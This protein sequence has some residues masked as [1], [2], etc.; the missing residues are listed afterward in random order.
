MKSSKNILIAGILF[1]SLIACSSNDTHKSNKN[2]VQTI[3]SLKHSIWKRELHASVDLDTVPIKNLYAFGPMVNLKGDYLILNGEAFQATTK[4]DKIDVQPEKS[5]KSPYLVYQYVPKWKSIKL[6]EDVDNIEDMETFVLSQK[7]LKGN[8]ETA[9]KL[10]GTFKAIELAVHNLPEKLD[11]YNYQVALV[12]NT[13]EQLTDIEGTVLGFFDSEKS[14][15]Y[16]HFNERMTMYFISKDK[17]KMGRITQL[18]IYPKD[19]KFE[20]PQY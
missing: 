7:G 5:G 4:D 12:A 1:T 15:K 19:V 13:K 8:K 9:F 17:K 11:F 16:T 6:N 3:G 10:N 2:T 20:L 14:M 18:F